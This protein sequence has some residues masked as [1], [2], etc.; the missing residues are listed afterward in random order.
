M[1]G[2]RRWSLGQVR[3]GGAVRI[4]HQTQD[5][6]AFRLED[7]S[8][9]LPGEVLL[10]LSRGALSI[11]VVDESRCVVS[12]KSWVASEICEIGAEAARAGSLDVVTF[13]LKSSS[14]PYAF[15]VDSG[16]AIVDVWNRLNPKAASFKEG[17]AD[18]NASVSEPFANHRIV[19]V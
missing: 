16:K 8:G 9:S 5:F 10:C 4:V 18:E 6:N 19:L 14:T 15:H 2:I 13:K 3:N 7:P 11:C 12:L 17:E 1:H